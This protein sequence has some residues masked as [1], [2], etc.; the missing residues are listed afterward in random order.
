LVPAV[1]FSLG[2]LRDGLPLLVP[3]PCLHIDHGLADFHSAGIPGIVRVGTALRLSG[4][5]RLEL[6][7]QPVAVIAVCEGGLRQQLRTGNTLFLYACLASLPRHPVLWIVVAGC[8]KRIHES[9][10]M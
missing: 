6:L 10:G 3:G 1:E 5:W 2:S 9:E 4:G 7:I 8:R